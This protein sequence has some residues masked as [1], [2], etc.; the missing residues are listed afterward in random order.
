V[1][2]VSLIVGSFL[3]WATVS[4]DVQAFA[5]LLGLDASSIEAGLPETSISLSGMD[6]DDGTITLIAGIAALVLGVI[7]LLRARRV[8]A[9]LLIV[10]G[11]IGGGVALYDVSQ[12]NDAKQEAL[13]EVEP[14]VQAIGLDASS[15]G[16][17]LDVSLGVGIWLCVFA[18][19][20]AI[21]GGVV[22][23][24]TGSAATTSDTSAPR[25]AES[26]AP[27]API[28]M[29][30]SVMSPGDMG[31]AAPTDPMPAPMQPR[32]APAGGGEEDV[33]ER[34]GRGDD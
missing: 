3:T 31:P 6:V 33:D 21:A 2:A 10:A 17:I 32:P 22:G 13:A 28:A 29:T 5:Q 9:A 15:I 4:I 18:G 24:T 27:P 7:A 14:V 34:G 11:L 25:R 30:P 19:L 20:V 23:W 26:E 12:A 16:E 1:A 8:V